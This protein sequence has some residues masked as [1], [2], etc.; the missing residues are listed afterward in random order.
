[1][2]IH[3]MFEIRTRD[4]QFLN[5]LHMELDEYIFIRKKPMCDL[6]GKT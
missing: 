6:G 5:T 3:K 4:F 2:F 1:M